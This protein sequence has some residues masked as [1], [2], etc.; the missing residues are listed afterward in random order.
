M[1]SEKLSVLIEK[2]NA[3]LEKYKAK[4]EEYNE[5]IR[6]SET[7]LQEYKMMQNSRMFDALSD[8]VVKS[9]LSVDDILVALQSGNL[10]ALQEQLEAAQSEDDKG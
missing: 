7:K 8:V 4:R 3:A 2:E 1:T 6:K 9:G 10:L 5:K